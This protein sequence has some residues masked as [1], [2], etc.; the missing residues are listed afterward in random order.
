MRPSHHPRRHA[1]QGP[2]TL[3]A[4]TARATPTLMPATNISH[5]SLTTAHLMSRQKAHAEGKLRRAANRSLRR[6]CRELIPSLECVFVPSVRSRTHRTV[7]TGGSRG[8]QSLRPQLGRR[9]ACGRGIL[10][11]VALL[12]IT[13]TKHRNR[14]RLACRRGTKLEARPPADHL[15]PMQRVAQPAAVG[16]LRAYPRHNQHPR[17]FDKPRIP[18]NHRYMDLAAHC[19]FHL[20]RIR[21]RRRHRP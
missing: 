5:F 18:A 11:A 7:G 19:L 8:H 9:M 1:S 4:T 15:E 16:M 12:D 6:R 2:T 3:S 13:E 10:S 20:G 17:R 14:V 21:F